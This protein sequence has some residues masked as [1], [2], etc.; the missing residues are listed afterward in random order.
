MRINKNQISITGIKEDL[1]FH[2]NRGK[3]HLIPYIRNR[4]MW[5][6]FPRLGWVSRFPDHVDVEIST[7]CNMQCPMCYTPTEAFKRRVKKGFMEF[8]LFKKIISECAENKVYSIRLSLRGEPFIHPDVLKM[9]AYA[10]E[11]GIKEVSTLTNLLALDEE[12]FRGLVKLGMDWLTISFDGLGATYEDIR[13][14]ARFKEGYGKIKRFAEIKRE[15]NSRKPA[16]K[17]QTIWPAIKENPG[18]FYDTFLPY[19]DQITV[20]PLIDYLHNDKDIVYTNGFTCPVLWQRLV[21]GYDGKVLL[22]SNDEM[23]KGI[24]GNVNYQTIKEIW[25]GNKINLMR[26]LHREK[27]AYRELEVCREC[28]FPRKLIEKEFVIGNRTYHIKQYVNRIDEIG[29]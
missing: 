24:L 13:K 21:I 11:K 18:E 10:K 26:R 25:H 12:M 15:M 6:Y 29:K 3:G 28:H 27:R 2:Y 4:F 9:L 17:I 8:P 7:L 22:C 1:N 16:I 5:H 14:P 20:N 19:V 23:G